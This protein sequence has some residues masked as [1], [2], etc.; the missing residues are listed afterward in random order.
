MHTLLPQKIDTVTANDDYTL[1]LTFRNG[2]VRLF[3][4]SPYLD[5]SDFFN[6]LAEIAYF[7]QAFP[8]GSSIEWSHGQSLCADTLFPC[9][10]PIENETFSENRQYE[11]AV[12]MT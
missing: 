5:S 6:E 2:E 10:I 1:T 8:D 3:D 9:G 12:P 7:R 4:I 11:L